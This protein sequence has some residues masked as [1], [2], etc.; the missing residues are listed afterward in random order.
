MAISRRPPP[1]LFRAS[2]LPPNKI[3]RMF[4]GQLPRRRVL[5]RL[6]TDPSNPFPVSLHRISSDKWAGRKPSGPPLEPAGKELIALRTASAEI[7]QA[8]KLLGSGN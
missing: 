6:T 1:G 5:T 8:E 7:W 4:G 2:S 3:S